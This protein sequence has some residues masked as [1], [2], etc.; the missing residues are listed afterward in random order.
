MSL[1]MAAA[2]GGATPQSGVRAIDPEKSTVPYLHGS[3]PWN[4]P[5]VPIRADHVGT[6]AVT[7]DT[8]ASFVHPSVLDFASLTPSGAFGGHRYWMANSDYSTPGNE[9]TM[10]LASDDGYVW[11]QP[12]GARPGVMWT[13]RDQPP[14]TTDVNTDPE[15]VWDTARG[16]LACLWRQ[17]S[18]PGRLWISRSTDGITWTPPALVFETDRMTFV[19]PCIVPDGSGG[20]IMV[21]WGTSPRRRT[22]P[23]LTGP[24]STPAALTVTG[25]VT[26]WHGG[27]WRDP[28]TGM[29]YGV[30][31]TGQTFEAYTSP[32]GLAWTGHGTALTQRLG[33]WD[34]DKLYR[35]TIQPHPD[36]EHFRVWYS[37]HGFPG[38]KNRTG[39]TVLPRSLWT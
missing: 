12:A 29:F 14:V 25:G 37:I 16:E 2:L 38:D 33:A 36:G 34:G 32:D 19:S 22:A 8:A 35:P 26:P 15:L 21:S 13:N 18:T 7:H 6:G 31:G 20:W 4:N 3:L 28:S 23:S 17:D 39:Y 30:G 1:I 10:L 5:P 11:R 27:V 24:W 9:D